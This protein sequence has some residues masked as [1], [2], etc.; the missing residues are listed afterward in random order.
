MRH[1]KAVTFYY[2]ADASELSKATESDV[3]TDD[4]SLM[5]ADIWKDILLYATAAYANAVKAMQSDWEAAQ[6]RT[7]P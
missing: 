2:D 1:T 6:D 5:R 7:A 4:T 3:F